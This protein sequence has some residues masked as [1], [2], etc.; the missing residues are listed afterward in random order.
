M[1]RIP[2]ILLGN[3]SLNKSLNNG[4]ILES[5][6]SMQSMPRLYLY[7]K[8]EREKVSHG[9]GVVS[10]EL[11]VASQQSDVGGQQLES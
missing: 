4:G 6:V 8:D 11:A 7:S 2:T 9:Q 10:H 1:S 5:R 3:S